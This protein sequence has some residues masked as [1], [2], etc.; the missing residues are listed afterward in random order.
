MAP[1]ERRRRSTQRDIA[2]HA[3][4]SQATV[5]LVISGGAASNQIAEST[6]RAVLAAAEE[7]GYAANVAARSLKGGRNR[8]LG[9]YTFESVF[10]TDQRDFYYPFL[11]GVAEETARQ[12]YD[13]LLFSSDRG[14]SST[15]TPT[16]ERSIYAGGANRLKIADGCVLLGRNVR[17]EEL[18][19]LV[20]ED[21][22]FVFV[23]RREVDD[24]ELSYVAADYVSATGALV[25][26]LARLGHRRILYLRA[27]E[28]SEPTRDREEGYRRGLAEAG[29]VPDEALIRRLADPADLSVD[30]LEEWIG[31]LGITALLVEPTEDDRLTGA[32]ATMAG[33][34][35]VRFPADCSLAL[36]GDPP[37]WTPE[38][39]NWTRFSLPRA[40]MAGEAVR[41]LIGLL[42]RESPEPRQLTVPCEFVPGDSIGP[43]PARPVPARPVP[44]D[45]DGRP[46]T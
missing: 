12:G 39:R 35:R 25:A 7:L 11:L 24:G 23:G 45:P 28:D 38:S 43:V 2:R 4:V 44:A 31:G 22:P 15:G 20:R 19:A 14:E 18:S 36:L 40:R 6:R 34:E 3:G 29:I 32:L 17:R 30:H 21:F 26:E 33:T 8:L 37:S 1:P 13:L 41:V 27:L 16:A 9:L 42:D 46:T 10:P 5:S